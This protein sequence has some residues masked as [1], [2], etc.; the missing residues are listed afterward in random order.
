MILRARA[1]AVGLALAAAPP[2]A[3]AA[4]DAHATHGFADLVLAGRVDGHIAPRLRAVLHDDASTY[5]A[6][7]DRV[8]PGVIV[9]DVA[10]AR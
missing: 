8:R 2:A 5:V 4:M 7:D 9:P 3:L 6:K 10:P 1:V